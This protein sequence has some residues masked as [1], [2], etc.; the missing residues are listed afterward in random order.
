MRNVSAQLGWRS[1]D[2]H[3]SRYHVENPE[4]RANFQRVLTAFQQKMP[5]EKTPNLVKHW[6]FLADGS[7]GCVGKLKQWL[8]DAL[9]VALEENEPTLLKEHLVATEPS[10]ESIL[11]SATDAAEGEGKLLKTPEKLEAL[12]RAL[13]YKSKSAATDISGDKVQTP[14]QEET[15][16]SKTQQDKPQGQRSRRGNVGERSPEQR[17]PTQR[18]K[19]AQ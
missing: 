10:L 17:D 7:I 1:R 8:E 15:D 2:I 4:D 18:G 16:D 14:D 11:N 19:H 9:T 3:F 13:G 12:R 5:L 6:R